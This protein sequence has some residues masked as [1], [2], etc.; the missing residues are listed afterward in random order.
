MVLNTDEHTDFVIDYLEDV[1][2]LNAAQKTKLVEIRKR[3]DGKD[4]N[5]KRFQREDAPDGQRTAGR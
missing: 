1:L 4:G 3:I 2:V 5:F